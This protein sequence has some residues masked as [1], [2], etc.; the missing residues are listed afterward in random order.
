MG[1]WPR[2]ARRR[3]STGSSGRSAGE[4]RE[5]AAANKDAMLRPAGHLHGVECCGL[6]RCLKSDHP[7]PGCCAD[8]TPRLQRGRQRGSAA[9]GWSCAGEAP[10]MSGIRPGGFLSPLRATVA[11]CPAPTSDEDRDQ[12][13]GRSDQSR[14][15][16]YRLWK[17]AARTP[18]H[19]D[20]GFR[21]SE[22]TAQLQTP[23]AAASHPADACRRCFGRPILRRKGSAEAA[24]HAW[25]PGCA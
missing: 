11:T 19:R 2:N 24:P 18:S 16:L 3:G 10:A 25:C 9:V 20:G 23:R 8:G 4:Y 13:G 5:G 15:T 7:Q 17:T 14:P 1:T 21:D 22:R 6:P 12:D